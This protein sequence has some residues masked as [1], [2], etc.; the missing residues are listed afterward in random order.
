MIYPAL[1][2]FKGRER[3]TPLPVRPP[4]GGR[5]PCGAALQAHCLA[6][7]HRRFRSLGL[8]PPPL[9]GRV[10]EGGG[11]RFNRLLITSAAACL[12]MLTFSPAAALEKISIVVFGP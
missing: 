2:H 12:F 10:G 11:N 7:M 6:R 8:L 4:Q 9:R 1:R 3:C 5:E